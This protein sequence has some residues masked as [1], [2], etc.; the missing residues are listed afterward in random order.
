MTALPR[1]EHWLTENQQAL[2]QALA[3]LRAYVR[4]EADAA[5]VA[6]LSIPSLARIARL[7]GLSHF[8]ASVLLL[9]A[10][11]ELDGTLRQAYAARQGT[12]APPWATF[13]LALSL[14]PDGHWSA[15]GASAPLR[16]WCLIELDS[17]EG[18][19]TGRLRISETVLH[20][21]LGIV[22]LDE[23]LAP[24][25]RPSPAPEILAP[26]HGEALL[27]L[28]QR[29][30]GPRENDGALPALE[31]TGIDP[32]ELQAAAACVCTNAGL[33]LVSIAATDLS[34]Q[35]ELLDIQLRRLQRDL[36]LIDACLLLDASE[37]QDKPTQDRAINVVERI[38][39]GPIVIARTPLRGWLRRRPY[40]Y[41][42]KVPEGHDRKRLWV[43]ALSGIELPDGALERAMGQFHLSASA[44]RSVAQKLRADMNDIDTAAP[45]AVESGSTRHDLGERLWLHCRGEGAAALAGLAESV[46]VRARWDDLVLPEVQIALLRSLIAHLRSRTQVFDDWGF[47]AH[48]ARGLGTAALF[49]GASGTGKTMAA[50]IVA[51]ALQLDLWRIDLSQVVSKWIGETEKNLAQIF[52]AADAGGAV[53]LF[54]EADAL[55]GKR[56]EVK[57]SHDRYANL[58][59]SFLLQRM[60]NYRGLAV[61]TTNNESA[62]D[63]AFL[64]RLRVIVPF[65]FPD[66]QMRERIWQRI[67]PAQTPLEGVRTDKLA[68]L[69]FSGGTIRNVALTAAFL[70]A[71]AGTPITMPHLRTAAE[72]ES[73]KIKR[74]FSRTETVDWL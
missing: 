72:I 74:P 15:L 55:F 68:R 1:S 56:S 41:S 45:D 25:M 51:G 23:R 69:Q 70:A 9:C 47:A 10:A 28:G 12:D 20:H 60:E 67:F 63:Q 38:D 35:P 33:H 14:F 24:L 3:A 31:L 21:L 19:V 36:T 7:F 13:G 18:V 64:R 16:Y 61:L 73:T 48:S 43:E 39:R 17:T 22:E 2:T 27:R 54:D 32:Q 26:S 57:D 58:E 29:W 5:P 50:E 59:I 44:L 66:A 37:T 6:P 65:P 71:G 30:P 53:L 34:S 62:L 11:Q 40:S 4:G 42:L 46:P 8:E 52:D 49:C